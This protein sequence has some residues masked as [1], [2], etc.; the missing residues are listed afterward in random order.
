M[1]LLAK[2]RALHGAPKE[3]QGSI[4]WDWVWF[5]SSYKASW[6]LS[7]SDKLIIRLSLNAKGKV[8]YIGFTPLASRRDPALRWRE[9]GADVR[10]RA[11]SSSGKGGRL[12]PCLSKHKKMSFG[13]R[14]RVGDLSLESA[15]C[16]R[17]WF[18]AA[19]QPNPEG[20]LSYKEQQ[21]Y[22]ILFCSI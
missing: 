20:S 22:L 21:H 19:S 18:G 6:Q 10:T 16:P 4:C 2:A 15:F 8:I 17:S 12:A 3:G 9:W 1:L 5:N 13:K 7:R 14:Q 11:G